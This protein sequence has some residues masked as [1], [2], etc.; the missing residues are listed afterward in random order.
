M[1]VEAVTL[2]INISTGDCVSLHTY[3]TWSDLFVSHSM[4]I[5]LS[6]LYGA[7]CALDITS[8][9]RTT[10]WKCKRKTENEE[11]KET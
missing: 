2:I 7:F 5:A 11:L 9:L 8:S 3:V 6:R 1:H 4:S 10:A